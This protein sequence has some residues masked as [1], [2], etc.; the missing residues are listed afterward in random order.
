[1][2][3]MDAL[4]YNFIENEPII[5]LEEFSEIEAKILITIIGRYNNQNIINTP[6]N[7]I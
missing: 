4:C 1:M 6:F 2:D 7:G 5:N 3:Y